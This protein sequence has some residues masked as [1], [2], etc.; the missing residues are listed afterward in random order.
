MLNSQEFELNYQLSPSSVSYDIVAHGYMKNDLQ[1]SDQQNGKK[2]L[3]VG[4]GP[5][6]ILL[7]TIGAGPSVIMDPVD[8]V[9]HIQGLKPLLD[10]KGIEFRNCKL[11]DADG[12]GDFD[13]VWCYNVLPHTSTPNE[14]LQSLIL[15]V[16]D[17]G[18]VR[19][20]EPMH[21]PYEHH[22]TEVTSELLDIVR[23]N[24]SEI[25]VD[26][27]VNYFP[28]GLFRNDH[29][30]LIAKIKKPDVYK[31]NESK[32]RVHIYGLPHTLTVRDDPRMMTCAYTTKVWLLCK[33]LMEEGHEV[34]HYGVE[35][36]DVPCTE[37]VPY[38]PFDM[39][40]RNYGQRETTSF[41]EG[42]LNSEVYRYAAMHLPDEINKRIRDP[43]REVV[44]AS[45]G[46]WAPEL[47]N[48]NKA[49]VI[50][51][52]VG[53][54]LTFTPYRAF[55]SYAWQHA[56]YGKRG[57]LIDF[58][59][60][61]DAVI[62]GYI[63]PEE[64]E[65]SDKKENYLLFVGRIMDTKGV[66]VAADLA[67]KFG[68]KIKI[69]GNGNLDWMF[70]DEYKD[71]IEYVGVV[72]VEEKKKLYRDAKATLCMTHYVEP[73]GNVHM[74][75]LMAGTPVITTDWG[76]YTETVGHGI[77][78]YRVRTWED[79]IF[80]LK[81]IDKISSKRCR[82]WA[83]ATWSLDAVYPKFEAYFEKCAAHFSKQ[84]WYFEREERAE[85]VSTYSANYEEYTK[86]H[87]AMVLNDDFVEKGLRALRS[88]G[89]H[90]DHFDISIIHCGLSAEN[91]EKLSGLK[92]FKKFIE[93]DGKYGIY[94]AKAVG[95]K[96][97]AISG[98]LLVV[99]ADILFRKDIDEM[100]FFS[101]G[102]YIHAADD[103]ATPKQ[104]DEFN[105]STH[106]GETYFQPGYFKAVPN[107]KD[108]EDQ[109]TA[110][111]GL[112]AIDCNNRK[113]RRFLTSLF[114]NAIKA[115]SE[116]PHW[117]FEQGLFNY[118]I[119]GEYKDGFKMFGQEFNSSPYNPG[120]LA[121]PNISLRVIHYHT[122]EVLKQFE[123]CYAFDADTV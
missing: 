68:L 38:I 82:E 75:S 57:E 96:D 95:L 90:H 99:D 56:V 19:I 13:E 12:P 63:D 11:E 14:F 69:A 61:T 73:F 45:F 76:V 30:V 103:F 81:N 104:Q 121:S 98:K 93:V 71:T 77:V 41:H 87:V 34:I 122:D 58:K 100:L 106:Q 112:I 6:S 44:L 83:M 60:W 59:G 74:E 16:R 88:F 62:P 26:K 94:W 29:I 85:Y 33:K 108:F 65:F 107:L 72:G 116:C 21:K 118:M 53:Y 23:R 5:R 24:S 102:K 10:S 89:R 54:D 1:I 97:V 84:D 50:E 37:N 86:V 25:L 114:D 36:S 22:P 55:E 92:H 42:N 46:F 40:D 91:K 70:A 20:M 110:N 119:L 4:G 49:A 80:A 52:G 35:G 101:N 117:P 17:G 78:G 67:K 66:Y 15:K 39:W 120:L 48:I 32:L 115:Y 31:K 47:L 9:A 28:E 123:E 43:K 18:I 8:Y 79:C 105:K 3:D 64:F 111:C 113:S 109:K 7:G 27:I 2:I 51:F